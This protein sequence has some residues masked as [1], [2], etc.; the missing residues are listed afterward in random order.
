MAGLLARHDSIISDSGVAPAAE[1]G[2]PVRRGG[3]AY[4]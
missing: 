1:W 4:V 2:R 3:I